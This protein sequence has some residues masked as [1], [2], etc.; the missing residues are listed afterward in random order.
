METEK[1][2]QQQQPKPLAR[3]K[4]VWS[5]L[6]A[7]LVA[8]LYQHVDLPA[9]AMPY[10]Q[11]LIAIF[12]ATAAISMRDAIKKSGLLAFFLACC[13]LTGC[14]APKMDSVKQCLSRLQADYEDKTIVKVPDERV[15]ASRLAMIRAA[16]EVVE[17]ASK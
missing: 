12:A 11:S 9:E 15:R 3:S 10:I 7:A 5:T 4:T 13:L 17:E 8:I 14:Q 16:K 6:A 1:Q 2:Q